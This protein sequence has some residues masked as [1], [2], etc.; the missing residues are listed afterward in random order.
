MTLTVSG[1]DRFA[2]EAV[3]QNFLRIVGAWRPALLTHGYAEDTVDEW[4]AK[5]RDEI[6]NMKPHI[7]VGVSTVLSA[8]RILLDTT[9]FQ[10]QASWALKPGHPGA[11]AA[12][13]GL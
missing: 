9:T 12:T 13:S 11:P 10:L 3:R 1:R 4:I 7:Y 5:A 8:F 6:V 2:S